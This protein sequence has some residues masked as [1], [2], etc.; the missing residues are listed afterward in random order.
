MAVIALL[1]R[2]VLALFTSVNLVYASVADIPPYDSRLDD[3][4]YGSYSTVGFVSSS[5][6]A[7]KA[8]WVRWSSECDDGLYYFLTPKGWK[9]PSPGPMI[10]D[11]DGSLIWTHHYENN[12]GG[13][14]YDLRVQ[15]YKGEEYLTVWLGDDRVKGHG[16]GQ[17]LMLNSSYHLVRTVTAADAVPADLHEFLITPEDTG[18]ISFFD[19]APADLRYLG[20]TSKWNQFVWDSVFQELDLDTNEAL[21]EWRASHHINISDTYREGATFTQGSQQDPV[22]WFHLNSVDKDE[23]GNYLITARYTHSIYYINGKTGSIIWTLGGKANKFMD[24]SNGYA[25]NFAWQHDARFRQF[26]AFPELYTPRK[27]VQGMTTRLLSLFDNADED[28]DR[29]YNYGSPYSRGLLLEVTYPT[30]GV[31]QDKLPIANQLEPSIDD[32]PKNNL[33]A[34]LTLED[35]EKIHSIN[36]TNPLYTVRV[37]QE[38][39][40]EDGQ[41]HSLSQGS[42]QTIPP[43]DPAKD[44]TFL[45]GYGLAAVATRLSSS[46]STI[47]DLHFGSRASWERGDVQSYRAFKLKWT[48]RPTYRPAIKL[49]KDKLY[50]SW[51]G[52]TEV[53]EWLV[54]AS[55]PGAAKVTNDPDSSGIWL[56][57]TSMAKKG[58]ET[59]VT[60]PPEITISSRF[61]RVTAIDAKGHICQNGVSEILDRG[62]V[63]IFISDKTGGRHVGMIAILGGLVGLT[64]VIDLARRYWRRNGHNRRKNGVLRK[65]AIE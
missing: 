33:R 16:F 8:N 35:V 5:V 64:A 59:A 1:L 15:Q 56:E 30:P 34:P 12:F 36:G 51:N 21:F 46:G 28:H 24:L 25:L 52:A 32:L 31:S 27:K 9:V 48:G 10:L 40:N 26:S 65:Y 50:V 14:A 7:P 61:I 19:V 17:F 6:K 43:T 60:L 29:N 62:Y 44:S 49:V 55:H 4:D 45:L 23:L 3:G 47:C 20:R 22:D 13:Q 57:V 39:I 54:E 63:N 38:F 41:L 53:R 58:F 42:L 18:L 37:I 2:H 11:A